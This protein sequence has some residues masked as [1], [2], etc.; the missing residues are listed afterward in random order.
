MFTSLVAFIINNYKVIYYLLRRIQI[1][2][3]IKIGY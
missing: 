2:S 1:L 3:I